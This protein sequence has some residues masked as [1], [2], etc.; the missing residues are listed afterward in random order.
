MYK[1]S[2]KKKNTFQLFLVGIVFTLIAVIAAGT[3]F[4]AIKNGKRSKTE[5][6]PA[7]RNL[8]KSLYSDLGRLRAVTEEK[9]PVVIFPVLEYNTAD[10]QFQ[11]ELVQKKDRLRAVIIGWFSQKS[12]IEL[13]T[14]PEQTV[15][16]ELL[17]VVNSILDLSEIRR[18]YFK[19]FIILGN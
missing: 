4:S 11:E 19:E 13:Y 5:A 3:V 10:L 8:P 7:A 2:K 6:P 12:A 18:I 16:K 17:A 9:C 15:K 1:A 14:M